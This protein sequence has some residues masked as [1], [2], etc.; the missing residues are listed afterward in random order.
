[1]KSSMEKTFYNFLYHTKLISKHKEPIEYIFY[2]LTLFLTIFHHRGRGRGVR[3]PWKIPPNLLIFLFNPSLRTYSDLRVKIE[4][5]NS[6][7]IIKKGNRKTS[8]DPTD[9]FIRF[10][11]LILGFNPKMHVG[12]IIMFWYFSCW[13][14]SDDCGISHCLCP[15]HYFQ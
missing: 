8:L 13:P 5:G 10:H 12:W 7:F 9:I 3:P 14:A 2:K 11:N 15:S 1:M 6:L 4:W